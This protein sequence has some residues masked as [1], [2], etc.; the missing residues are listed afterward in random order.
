MNNYDNTD[1][2]ISN[3]FKIPLSIEQK[4]IAKKLA[5]QIAQLEEEKNKLKKGKQDKW[6]EMKQD[7]KFLS[8]V[9]D[10]IGTDRA[11]K[12]KNQEWVVKSVPNIWYQKKGMKLI[13]QAVENV[14]GEDASKKL[15]ICIKEK[16]KILSQNLT[17]ETT[18]I[19]KRKDEKKKETEQKKNQFDRNSKKRRETKKRKILEKM[20]KK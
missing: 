10:V 18:V 9:F 15:K 2:N 4:E 12:D 8:N 19:L 13:Y 11:I 20:E 16:K 17:C 3:G 7:K 14:L 5:V 1:E 6:D